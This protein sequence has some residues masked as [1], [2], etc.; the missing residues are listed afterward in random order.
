MKTAKVTVSPE[1]EDEKQPLKDAMTASQVDVTVNAETKKRAYRVCLLA[2]FVDLAG[3]V[4]LQPNY[5][6]MVGNAPGAT[7]SPALP[8]NYTHPHAFP[9]DGQLPTF[10]IAVNIIITVNFIGSTISN[11]VLGSLSDR[12]GRR[13]IIILGIGMGCVTL[14]LY[15]VAGRYAKS[16]WLFVGLQFLNGLFGGT[17][18]VVQAYIQDIHEPAEFAKLQPVIMM[19]FIFGAAAGGLIGGIVGGAIRLDQYSTDLFTGSLVGAG[20]SLLCLVLVLL[21]VPEPPRPKKAPQA[22]SATV[23]KAHTSSIVKRILWILVIAS[24]FD[25][26]G[27]NGN[28]FARN[29]VFTNRYPIGKEPSMNTLLLVLSVIGVFI[30]MILVLTT[31]KK[32]KISLPV[33]CML[34]N[35]AS[36]IAQFAVIPTALPVVGFFA[37]FM[38]A[39]CFGFTST[40]ATMFLL[41]RF[42]PP[43]ARGFWVGLQGASAQ[44]G[45][46]VAPLM[47]SGIYAATSPPHGSPAVDYANAELTCLVITGCIS[48]LAFFLFSPLPALIPK[49]EKPPPPL[50]DVSMESYLNMTVKDFS[51]LDLKTRM[52]VNQKLITEGKTPLDAHWT[53]YQEDRADGELDKIPDRRPLPQL[54]KPPT[55]DRPRPLALRSDT[56]THL[57]SLLVGWLVAAWQERRRPFPT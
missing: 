41:P 55:Q 2:A 56:H 40:L 3:A 20:A 45:Q 15:Y 13:P 6:A 22:A 4:I 31:S 11:L 39:R 46:A 14:A 32:G 38:V 17:K 25:S 48:L 27:D 36:A 23:E 19:A 49:P 44:F 8:A 42:A 10:T 43:E 1:S 26:F 34:G 51:R 57:L 24:G 54:P 30:A 9:A 53:S 37:C 35:L 47:L 18:G 50:D 5:P 33:W 7:R 52:S 12:F 29:T 21:Y 16:Y 28:A